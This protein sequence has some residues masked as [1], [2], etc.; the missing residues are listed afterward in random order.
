[1][2]VDHA[3]NYVKRL[4]DYIGIDLGWTSS[5]KSPSLEAAYPFSSRDGPLQYHASPNGQLVMTALNMVK[6]RHPIVALPL[7]AVIINA[8]TR[9]EKP[10]ITW[11]S[12]L[13]AIQP[14]CTTYS[15]QSSQPRVLDSKNGQHGRI[16]SKEP[17][18]R[19]HGPSS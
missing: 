2:L 19:L 9:T 13:C 16:P 18:L 17:C 6:R 5:P 7:L 1:M 4:C 10:V 8:D 12:T 11:L 14:A 15:G 3:N